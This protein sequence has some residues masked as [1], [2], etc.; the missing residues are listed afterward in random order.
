MNKEKQI[1]KAFI[2][3]YALTKGIYEAEGELK[4]GRLTL[5]DRWQW[6][7][8]YKGEF[9]FTREEAVANAEERR[10]KKLQSLDK[11]AKKIS[12]IKF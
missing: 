5:S 11:Q 6:T 9:F 3:K 1:V 7:S 2:T 8:F 12:A 10:I 4:D